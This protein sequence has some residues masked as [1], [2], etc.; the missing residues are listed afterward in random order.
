MLSHDPSGSWGI[1]WP[2]IQANSEFA[3][4]MVD[5]LGAYPFSATTTKVFQGLQER[6]LADFYVWATRQEPVSDGRGQNSGIRSETPLTAL[7]SAALNNLARRGTDA[8]CKEIQRIGTFLP[9]DGLKRVLRFA[10]DAFRRHTW[11]PVTPSELIAAARRTGPEAG[12]QPQASNRQ[13]TVKRSPRYLD[14][15]AKLRKIWDSRPQCYAKVIEALDGR[16]RHPDVEPFRTA[17]GW[18]KGFKKNPSLART[19]LSK[20][21]A[22]LGLPQLPRGPK[23]QKSSFQ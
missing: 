10:Q 2:V 8:A 6:Q 18:L 23:R 4:R 16:A 5:A 13:K 22:R 21:R 15:D 3:A 1:V 17:G 9:G 11:R 20:T 14:I 7:S 12:G 19:W